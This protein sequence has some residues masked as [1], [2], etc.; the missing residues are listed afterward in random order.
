MN[1]SGL[2]ERD[3]VKNEHHGSYDHAVAIEQMR[4]IDLA[5]QRYFESRNWIVARNKELPG[6]QR[7]SGHSELN[8]RS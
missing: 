6:L 3:E 7:R 4:A 8:W 2:L 1:K 5:M